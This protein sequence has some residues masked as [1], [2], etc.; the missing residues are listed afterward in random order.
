LF[1]GDAAGVL[2]IPAEGA[3][4]RLE[5]PVAPDRMVRVGAGIYQL[6]PAGNGTVWLLEADAPEPRVVF[7]PPADAAQALDGGDLR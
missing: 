5:S 2:R 6:N 4:S 1:A 3:P 7:V